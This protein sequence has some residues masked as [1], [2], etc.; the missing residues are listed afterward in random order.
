MTILTS[1]P[2]DLQSRYRELALRIRRWPLGVHMLLAVNL[3]LAV[4][5]LVLMFF[6]YR[7]GMD[8]A[9]IE[10]EISLADEAVAVHQA[11]AHIAHGHSVTST[12]EFIESVCL[13]M[14]NT[15]SPGHVI[16]VVRG[17][18]LLHS[19]EHGRLTVDADAALLR[20]FRRGLSRLQWNDELLVL[21][22]HEEDGT[23]V[24]IAELATNIRRVA[25]TDVLW[26]LAALAILAL[27]AATIMDAVLWRLIRSPLRRMAMTV[28]TIARGEVGLMLDLPVGRELQHLT[29]S[30]NRMSEALAADERRRQH[31][32]QRAHTIQQ[33]LLPSGV[34][35]PGL[36]IA[37]DYQP[38]EQVA[39]DYYDLLPLADGS[40]LLVIADVAGHGISAAM[41]ATLLK[42][43]LLCESENSY[44]PTE[45]LDRV[46]RRMSS[47]LPT[48]VFVTTLL[49][50]WNPVERRLNYVNA[51][52]PPGLLWNPRDGF[53]ELAASAVPVG[54]MPDVEYVSREL[55][56]T[57]S[58]RLVL[59]TDG[60]LEAF[61]PSGELFGT[62]RLKQLIVHHASATPSELLNVI[63]T[64]VRSFTGDRPLQDDLTLLVACPGSDVRTDP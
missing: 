7:D 42:A 50:V 23:A 36:T 16:L 63:R 46:N 56:L 35:I 15:G 33:H 3:P 14:Q 52:H 25:R 31:E 64:A 44:H 55:T 37:S 1:S 49:V 54:V 62:D 22:G 12:K 24:V 27:I 20:T 2:F 6:K 18:E 10:K 13:K 61:A 21:G 51:G 57:A 34:N 47:L 26:Q 11:V 30:F 38:A 40:W 4:L 48:G 19:T 29:R 32:I 9:I 41:V 43:L 28:K 39:G 17:D 5:L 45:I 58:D 8:Q 59:V 53:R 60:L